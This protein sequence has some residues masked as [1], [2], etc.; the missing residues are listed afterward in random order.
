MSWC[1]CIKKSELSTRI[2]DHKITNGN[3]SLLS[4]QPQRPLKCQHLDS[5]KYVGE[6]TLKPPFYPVVGE[7]TFWCLLQFSHYCAADQMIILFSRCPFKQVPATGGCITRSAQCSWFGS[8]RFGS[9]V[10]L[11]EQKP[12]FSSSL[13][14]TYASRPN[15]KGHIH[16][17]FQTCLIKKHFLFPNFAWPLSLQKEQHKGNL[18]PRSAQMSWDSWALELLL[19]W[20][21]DP[22]FSI[23]YRDKYL[24]HSGQSVS[25]FSVLKSSINV[26]LT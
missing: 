1:I 20:P 18:R 15:P 10:P 5:F 23:C 26:N 24:G 25:V 6:R 9:C 2:S 17:A 22:Y 4:P 8:A 19:F 16:T 7:W 14:T 12:N 3:S 21:T 11:L 13:P